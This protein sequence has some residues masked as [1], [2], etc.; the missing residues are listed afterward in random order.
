MSFNQQTVQYEQLHSIEE[1]L[2]FIRQL[3]RNAEFEQALQLYKNL[4]EECIQKELYEVVLNCF[5]GICQ[6]LANLG[7]TLEMEP[8]LTKY[9]K[10]CDQYGDDTAKLKLHSIIGYI[11][12][13]IEDYESTIYHYEQALL[14]ATKLQNVPR[15]AYILVNL[16]SVYLDIFDLSSAKQCTERFEQIMSTNRDQISPM[17]Y[18]GYLL[19]YMT[20]LIEQRNTE[21]L[22]SLFEQVDE[23]LDYEKFKREH[24]Y[25]LYLKGRYYENINEAHKAISYFEHALAYLKQ[26]HEAPYYKKVLKHL[27]Q[28]HKL[29]N[30]FEQATLCAELLIEDL[31]DCQ[32]EVL[33]Q[34]TVE[35]SKKLKL[36]ELQ[37]LIYFDGLTNIHN[38]RYLEEEG[39]KWLVQARLKDDQIGCG[40]IDIDNFKCI[41]DRFGHPFGD[42]VIKFFASQLCAEME[43][44]MMCVRYGGDEFIVLAREKE[45]YEKLYTKL[46]STLQG[47]NVTDGEKDFTIEISMG[48]SMLRGEELR[49]LKHLIS[50][51]DKALYEVKNVGK[52]NLVFN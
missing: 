2:E 47:M 35:L 51:A 30:Q 8:Y 29:L 50:H 52:N 44:N 4:K 27:V 33:Q 14:Y 46:F 16:Q 1:K 25:V 45:D 28:N 17:T 5:A 9:K 38:R 41:N 43:D 12:A 40:I 6:N 23:F 31:E 24:M 37:T 39:E 21:L 19:N 48:V 15:L 42:E 22:P 10:Y 26:T 49:S 3:N 7:R 18:S 32:R 20:I 13:T 36:H 34:K 11:S